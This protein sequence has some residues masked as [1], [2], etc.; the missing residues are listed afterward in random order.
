MRGRLGCRAAASAILVQH[1]SMNTGRL[2]RN[3]H[4]LRVFTAALLYF[5]VLIAGA[6]VTSNDAGLSVP[7]WPPLLRILRCFASNGRR[8]L[9]R[10]RPSH[11]RHVPRDIQHRSGRLALAAGVAQLAALVGHRR[12]RWSSRSGPSW[13]YHRVVFPAA[14]SIFGPR[15]FGAN[16]LC[17]YR[18]HC[19]LHQPED[20][21]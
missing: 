21:Q 20:R 4:S 6:L 16:L 13:R 18:E 15:H 8:H 1:S 12:R 3:V 2:N 11:G 9:L 17:H 5:F 19:I 10:A 7:D 14:G